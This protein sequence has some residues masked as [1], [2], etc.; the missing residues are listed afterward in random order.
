MSQDTGLVALLRHKALGCLKVSLNTVFVSNSTGLPYSAAEHWVSYL[1]VS[2]STGLPYSVAE[3]WVSCL[4]APQSTGL[5]YSF[6]VQN[7]GSP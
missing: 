2:K 6:A 5:T 1:I 7:T 3:H 4:I